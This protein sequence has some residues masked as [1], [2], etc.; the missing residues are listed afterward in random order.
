MGEECSKSCPG[1]DDASAVTISVVL[2]TARSQI[3]RN[4]PARFKHPVSM[5]AYLGLAPRRRY[6]PGL[7]YR[8]ST[9]LGYLWSAS[10]PARPG[11]LA[12]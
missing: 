10:M 1:R 9:A 12:M 2:S 5:D 8:S 4:D 3:A 6:S 11:R 7:H